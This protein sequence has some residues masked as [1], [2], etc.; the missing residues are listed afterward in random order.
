M[1]NSLIAYER[2]GDD[3]LTELGFTKTQ[4]KIYLTLLKTG[5]ATAKTLSN[6]ANTPRAIVYRT[7]DELQEMGVVE[8]EIT[9]PFKFRAVPLRYGLQVLMLRRLQQHKD[10]QEKAKEF[11]RN[12]N[13]YEEE[14]FEDDDYRFIVFQSKERIIQMMKLQ[15]KNVQRSAD[16]ISTW[17]RLLQIMDCCYEYY[18]QAL[19]RG[20]KY[21]IILE[22]P[23]KGFDFPRKLHE[24]LAT[25]NFRLRFSRKALKTNAGI[26]DKKEA[27]LNF[28]PSKS[29][30]ESPIIWTNHPSFLSMCKDHF[31]NAW[32]SAAPF[33]EAKR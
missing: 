17:H 26:F 18:S 24:L 3:F 9:A 21:R 4:T 33:E 20:V 15:H 29:L 22:K 25:P 6:K 2:K 27:T 16:I 23:K 31:N 13:D 7:L 12:I 30:K 5:N 10:L 28:Y 1:K 11:L 19:A 14:M 8:K 32:K